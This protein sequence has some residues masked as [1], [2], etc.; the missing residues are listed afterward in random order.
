MC[1]LKVGWGQVAQGRVEALA[2][3][4]DLDVVED[5]R[6]SN[7]VRRVNLSLDALGLEGGEEALGNGVIIADA[8]AP[9][10]GADMIGGQQG[11]ESKAM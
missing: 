1:L 3:V 10:T 7:V 5:V 4:E 6:T 2:I 11:L 8:G 9:H